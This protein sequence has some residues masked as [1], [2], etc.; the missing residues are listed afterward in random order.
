MNKIHI[1]IFWL[2]LI[3]AS[4]Y[5]QSTGNASAN[6]T[7]THPYWIEMMQNPDAN[8]YQTVRAFNLYWKDKPIERGSGYKPFK[9]WEYYWSTRLNDDGTR[10]LGNRTY[11]S[12]MNFINSIRKEGYG[13]TWQCL[14]PIQLPVNNGTGQPN[15][16]GRVNAIAFHPSMSGHLYV[17]AP[18]GGFWTSANGGIT[19]INHTDN[20]PTLG[21]SAIVIHPNNPNIIYIGTGDRDAGDAP[22]MGVYKATDGTTFLPANDNMPDAK[23]GKLLMDPLDPNTLLAATNKGVFKT[24]DGAVTWELKK[25]GNFKDIHYKPGNSSVVYATASGKFFRSTNYGNSWTQIAIPG[26]PSRAVIGVSPADADVVYF[27]GTKNSVYEATYKSTDAG[28]TWTMQS[29]SPNIMGYGCNGGSGGQGWYDLAVAVDPND[30]NTL[31]VGGVNVF[32]STNGG[33]T[34]QVNSHWVG[35]CGVPA[36][37]ADCHV[38]EFNPL[39]GRLYAGNDGGIYYTDNGGSSWHELTS[40][41]AISMIY[42]IGQDAINKD[43]VMNGY[44]DNGSG[45]YMGQ[46][47]GFLTILGGDGMD[48]LYDYDDDSYSYAE[49]YYG[50]IHRFH[51]NGYQMDISGNIPE[52]G[53]WVTPYALDVTDPNTMYVGMTNL[54]RGTN[55]RVYPLWEQITNFSGDKFRVIEQSEANPDVFYFCK[56]NKRF[57]RSDNFTDA[58]PVYADLTGSLPIQK[59]ITDI[60]TNPFDENVVY[61]T[62]DEKVY[63]SVNKGETWENITLNLPEASTNTIEYYKNDHEGLYVGTDAGIFYKNA[64]TSQWMLFSDGY[65]L[66]AN[67]TEIE[68]YYDSLS[69]ESDLVRASTYGRGLW[70]SPVW[71]G[72]LVAKFESSDTLIPLGCKVDFFDRTEGVPHHWKWHFEGAVPDSSVEKNPSNITYD[73]AGTFL[74]SLIVTNTGGSDTLIRKGYITVGE[75]IKPSV[76]FTSSSPSICPGETISFFD[77]SSGCPTS[78]KW[79]INPPTNIVYEENTSDTSQNPVIRFNKEGRYHVSLTVSNS[80][81]DSTLTRFNYVSAGG[82]P[83]PFSEDFENGNFDNKGWEVINSDNNITWQLIDVTEPDNQTGQCAYI[84]FYNYIYTGSRDQLISPPM[85]FEAFSTVYMTFDYAYAQRYAQTD[86]L[87]VK[88]SD[89]C[90]TNWTRVYADGPDMT[91]KFVTCEPMDTAFTPMVPEDWSTT[92]N[93]GA[94]SPIIDLSNWAGK[95]QIKILFESYSGYGNNLYLDNIEISNAVGIFNKEGSFNDL[96]GVYPNPASNMTN[97]SLFTEQSKYTLSLSDLNGK[98]LLKKKIKPGTTPLD[99]SGLAKGIY[100]VKVENGEKVKTE[101]LIIQ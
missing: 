96:F 70:S 79:S 81:G 98:V 3:S 12:V 95:S 72:P 18:A 8:Y 42:K 29:N 101:K 92:G 52:S 14:G 40:G 47:Q 97:I 77:N 100:L 67:T 75:N 91:Q 46:S 78:W 22:G 16:N 90:G 89:D 5:S 49:Y 94:S 26:S 93:F 65:P 50:S 54:W 73:S 20:L 86:S 27:V 9:R 53:A 23:V 4:V 43:K 85:S 64:D 87:I 61:I 10:K 69:P 45:T 31:Y 48:C 82:A 1:F 38:L 35:D 25:A 28:L 39:D 76:N 66:A 7:A 71:Y 55:V 19:W 44:Q 21:V 58:Q 80:A 56:D 59:M 84:N 24:T 63:K 74:V 68:I 17:G 13:G 62:I 36:V 33:V 83:V 11:Q 51:D 37:H 30:A 15:G 32:K 88:I 57:Y 99:V 2:L 60:E 6:D 34:W 41:L